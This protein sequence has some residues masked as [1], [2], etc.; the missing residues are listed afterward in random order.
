MLLVGD[1]PIVPMIKKLPNFRQ[2]LLPNCSV[3][4]QIERQHTESFLGTPN[5]SVLAISK[6]CRVLKILV[7]PMRKRIIKNN[8]NLSFC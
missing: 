1:A 2:K 5:M 7:S 3:P 8:E 6:W 4:V